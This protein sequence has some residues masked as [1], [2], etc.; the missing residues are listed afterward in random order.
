MEET[1]SESRDVSHK[2][3]RG[4]KK[5]FVI[6]GTII[7]ILTIIAVYFL[8]FISSD[9]GTYKFSGNKFSYST[10]RGKANYE[11]VFRGENSGFT[12]YNV[13]F[14]SRDFL[15]YK[16]KIYGILLFPKNKTND[17]TNDKT[18][19]ALVPGVVCFLAA[20]LKKKVNYALHHLLLIQ[21]MLF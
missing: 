17:K 3:K 13:S 4:R 9:G 20:V 15:N 8:F 16:T 19:E 1:K 12:L 18:N 2:A 21:V 5:L 6:L 7:L 14:Y 11:M 10:N